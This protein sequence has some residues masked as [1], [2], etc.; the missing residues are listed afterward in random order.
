M[1]PFKFSVFL[2]KH[3]LKRDQI[4]MHSTDWNTTILF[5]WTDIVVREIYAH[6][7]IYKTEIGHSLSLKPAE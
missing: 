7:Q 5:K 4:F 3:D 6:T 1:N 2:H